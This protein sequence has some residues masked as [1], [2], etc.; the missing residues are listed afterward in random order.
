MLIRAEQHYWPGPTEQLHPGLSAQ[1]SL[2]L[3]F[4]FLIKLI[5]E[6]QSNIMGVF[7]ALCVNQFSII[8]YI[9]TDFL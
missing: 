2:S 3:A 1:L 9:M 4:F 8:V 5:P 6:P 7:L